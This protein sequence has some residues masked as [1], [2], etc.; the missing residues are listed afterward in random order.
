M[1][2]RHVGISIEI[3]KW[4]EILII[5]STE[6]Y[7]AKGEAFWTEENFKYYALKNEMKKFQICCIEKVVFVQLI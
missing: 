4:C 5:I 6:Y 1:Q 2:Q 7:I 3:N